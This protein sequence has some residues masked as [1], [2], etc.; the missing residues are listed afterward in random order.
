MKSIR[1]ITQALFSV[2]ALTLA[3]GC[4]TVLSPVSVQ[5]SPL[6]AGRVLPHHAVLVLNQ[7]LADY[8]IETHLIGGTDVYP[9]GSAL[10]DYARNVTG[11]SFQ[12]IDVV[13]SEEKASS[14][15]SDDLILI[16]RA[17]KSDHSFGHG[18][19]NVTLVVEWTA[20]SRTSQNVVWL[21]TITANASEEMGSPFTN[22]KHRR[23]VFQKVFDDLSTRTYEAF[24]EAPEL[25]GSQP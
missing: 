24:Q 16:P 12:Q 13:P 7:E 4:T 15:T 2:L 9:I 23:H 17:V 18:K 20:K 5:Q 21:K 25:R 1:L 6:P 8:N 19:Y 3:S 11:K 10:Q 14:F 22:L